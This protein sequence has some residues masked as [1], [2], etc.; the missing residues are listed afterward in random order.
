MQRIGFVGLH[1]HWCDMQRMEMTILASIN[2]LKLLLFSHTYH[3]VQ[4]GAALWGGA[5]VDK[6]TYSSSFRWNVRRS[7]KSFQF[8]VLGAA[9]CKKANDIW[10]RIQKICHLIILGVCL[11]QAAECWLVYIA[12]WCKNTICK[13]SKSSS[14]IDIKMCNYRK[15]NLLRENHSIHLLPL[16]QSRVAGAVVSTKTP[17][18]FWP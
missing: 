2:S 14:A 10:L 16:L 7:T 9:F 17:R 8:N 11:Q 5:V 1:L 13:A 15:Y 6:S 12:W 4:A 18:P 3:L